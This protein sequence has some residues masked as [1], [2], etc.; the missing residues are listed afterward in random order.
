M[1]V[2]I[3]GSQGTITIGETVSGEPHLLQHRTDGR[4]KDTCGLSEKTKII[5]L[6]RRFGLR[7]RLLVWH[8]S[9]GLQRYSQGVDSSRCNLCAL[10]LPH[11][12]SLVSS[13]K[14]LIPLSNNLTF[15]AAARSHLYNTQLWCPARP[16]R[17]VPQDPSRRRE[18]G[19][20]ASTLRVQQEVTEVTR[21]NGC[22]LKGGLPVKN[23]S[24][25]RLS[26]F[27]E[28]LEGRPCLFTLSLSR[29]PERQHLLEW[30]SVKCPVC[31]FL[32]LVP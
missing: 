3:P 29:P 2:C 4:L 17:A 19:Y 25:G 23:T 12:T 18:S 27:P 30:S 9:K 31:Q 7:G 22:S 32:G 24:K 20:T 15:M 5:C 8:M 14:E 21:G 28:N 11:S 13:R 1:G 10:P 6:P 16:T 26:T